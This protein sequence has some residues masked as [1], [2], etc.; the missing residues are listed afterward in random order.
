M[1]C[2]ASRDD[3]NEDNFSI[4]GLFHNIKSVKSLTLGKD[5]KACGFESKPFIGLP[6]EDS[7]LIEVHF[8]TLT[9]KDRDDIL[10]P[11][12]PIHPTVEEGQVS[13]QQPQETKSLFGHDFSG[14]VVKAGEKSGYSKSDHVYGWVETGAFSDLIITK[15]ANISKVP[16]DIK[17]E[18][19]AS[20]PYAGWI[21]FKTLTDLKKDEKVHIHAQGFLVDFLKAIASKTTSHVTGNLII[22]K[23]I[24]F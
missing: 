17:L 7:V 3:K 2:C 16:K 4:F 24:L 19:A 1:F 21:A 20:L 10:H 23:M 13:P 8:A 11:V 22:K 12:Q 14:V 15:A 5:D 9:I 6:D 18:V